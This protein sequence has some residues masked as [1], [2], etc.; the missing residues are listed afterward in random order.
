MTK[1][2]TE[3]VTV[4][5]TEFSIISKDI[6][7]DLKSLKGDVGAIALEMPELLRKVNEHHGFVKD[8][9]KEGCPRPKNNPIEDNGER[10]RRKLDQKKYK[11]L[12]WTA[13]IGAA[14]TILFLIG[15]LGSMLITFGEILEQLPK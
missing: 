12:L 4:I 3:R 11:F 13:I 9:K 2:L 10:G 5:E 7:G 15:K 6:Q 8:L 14:G 1:T